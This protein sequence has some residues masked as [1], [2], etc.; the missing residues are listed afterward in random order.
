[1]VAG[2]FDD[3]R[4]PRRGARVATVIAFAALVV[5]PLVTGALTTGTPAALLSLP[6]ESIAVVLILLAIPSRRVR[7]LVAGA[8]G[9][10]VV[11]AAVVAA[12]DLGFEATVDRAFSLVDDGPALVDAF[13]VVGDATGTVNAFLIVGVLVAVLVVAVFALARAAMRAERVTVRS[14]RAGRIAAATVTGIWIV[15][16][17]VGVHSVPGIPLASADAATTLATTSEQTAQSIRDQQTFATAVRA[18]AYRGL[19]S[20]R[21]LSA[22]KGKDVVVAFIESYGKVAVQ[23]STFSPG[24]D[25]VLSAGDAQLTADG[26]SA[27]SAFLSSPTF[28]GVSWLA[29]S[30]LQSGVWTDS[31]QNYDRLTTG[32]RF[33]ITRAFK[34]AGWHTV[35]VVPSNKEPWA[36]GQQFYGY[37]TMMNSLNMGYQG[38]VF[39]YARIPDQYTWQYFYDQE[40]KAAHSPVMAEIDFVSSHTPWTPLP[41]LVPWLDVGDG[42]IFDPQPGEGLAPI[43]V[44]PDSKKVQAVYGKS[45][46]YTLGAMFSFLHTYDQPNLVLIVLGDHQPARIV[47]GAG[48]DHDVPISIISKD[49]TVFDKIA[50]WHWQSGVLPT[51]KAPV[52]RMDQFRDRF[53]DAFTP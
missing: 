26:Y 51:Q 12:L 27:Q 20:D 6:A 22:L 45:V 47:S 2:G 41:H 23:G 3:G 19:P 31:Q 34:D 16:A 52:W 48:A 10:A 17:L 13:G 21:L 38:P 18:D 24:V 11:A 49:P 5:A 4:A 40:L 15:A 44:W 42:S 53:F 35:S 8:F 25:R 32:D 50:S 7:W 39:S 46:E 36:L 29:H 37:D 1:M 9:V 30:T 14:G 28:G 33:T 43:A